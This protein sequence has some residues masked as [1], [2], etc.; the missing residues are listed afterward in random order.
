MK[1]VFH[2][3]QALHYPKHFLASGALKPN[4]EQPQRTDALL[5]GARAAGLEVV[6]P[7][8]YGLGSV[9]SVHSPEY[10]AF[11]K[12]I[13]ER[14]Q[15]IEGAS[16]EVVPNIH[17]D[18]RDVG[19]PKSAVGQVGYHVMD[20]SCPISAD[21][22]N[23]ARASANS[24]VHAA[25]LLTD[26]EVSAY[27]LC[28]PPGHH[29]FRDL[30]GGFCYFNN[31]AIAAQWFRARGLRPAIVDVDLHHGN[32]TQGIFYHR[33]DVLTVSVHADPIR[34]YPFFW[35]HAHERGEGEG[36]GYNLNLPIER[37]SGDDVFL[38]A[39]DKGLERV[40]LFA[41]DVLIVALGLDAFEGDP[42][43]GLSVTTAGFGRIG[44]AC[45]ALHLPTLMVQEGGYLCHE[46][47]DNLTR[48][49]EGF[50]GVSRARPIGRR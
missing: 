29:A 37:G 14:W 34:Y 2:P 26:G 45:A 8:D 33:A 6:T 35:G 25:H 1:A 12:H 24:A 41:P 11:L 21:T 15:R 36:R 7:D 10:I 18:T 31:T 17:P 47:G 48:F 44:A 46:L 28:R 27:A 20:T 39:L 50:G 19:Y 23:S 42:F 9:A 22:F 38:A 30:A 16:T 4:P 32:G 5:A 13:H 49:V 43:G 40:A 3:D